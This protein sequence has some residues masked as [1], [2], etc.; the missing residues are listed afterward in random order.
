M[1]VLRQ[2]LA[3]ESSPAHASALQERLL[4]EGCVLRVQWEQM[5]RMRW[6]AV[7]LRMSWR[8]VMLLMNR[9]VVTLRSDSRTLAAVKRCNNFAKRCNNFAGLK[10][11]ARN[12]QQG[13]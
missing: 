5:V 1:T 12:N 13:K 8:A 11:P 6:R 7:T 10:A 2:L 4:P 3:Q 9:R